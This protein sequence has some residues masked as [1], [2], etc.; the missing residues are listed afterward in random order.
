MGGKW[1]PPPNTPIRPGAYVNFESSGSTPVL[2]GDFG[3]VG[4]PIQANWGPAN[5]FVEVITDADRRT[6]YGIV[7]GYD[8]KT[9]AAPAAA[10]TSWLITEAIRGGSELVKAYRL[11][12][13]GSMAATLTLK[14]WTGSNELKIDAKYVG[15]R[16]NGWTVTVGPSPVFAGK[17]V[18][19]IT[20]GTTVLESWIYPTDD[21]AN[22]VT[23]LNSTTTGSILVTGTLVAGMTVQASEVTDLVVAAPLTAGAFG[24]QFNFG[25][26][27]GGVT[28]VANV[29]TT[30]GILFSASTVANVQTAV[31]AALVA[32]GFVAGNITVTLQVGSDGLDTAGAHTYRLTA[33]GA[34][35][36]QNITVSIINGPALVVPLAA[37]VPALGVVVTVI[38]AGA[39]SP[40]AYGAFVGVTGFNSTGVNGA[41]PNALSYTNALAAFETEGGFDLFSLD[42]VSEESIVGI[43][44]AIGA[45]AI[46][47]NDAG[48]Y[49]M[50]VVGGGATELANVGNLGVTSALSRSALYDSEWVVNIGVSGLDVTAPGGN[51]LSLTSAQCAPRLAGMIANAGIIGSVTFGEVT[52]VVK[53]NGAV[54]PAQIEAMIQ[55]GVIV[56]AK[57]GDFVRVEDGITTF[58]SLTDEKDFTFTQIRAVRAIQ[59]IGLDITEIVERDWIG[60]KINTTSVRDLLLATLGQYFSLLEARGVLV[61][62]TSVQLDTRYDNTKTNVFILVLAQFQFELK[63]VLLTVRVP[64]VA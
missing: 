26:T 45:W 57:R 8:N 13:A 16:P 4:M 47:N 2:P 61:A 14:D 3:R 1:S 33:S 46:I 63:R 48:R 52:D 53:V 41:A 24:I 59:Q 29:Q 28:P 51:T 20:E 35:A 17:D 64:T 50:A 44:A 36:N 58:I 6:T 39:R 25:N 11:V 32:G 40:L 34:L 21:V 5:A 37:L 19:T 7:D 42:G 23:Q 22:L 9:T 60:K 27:T 62:G 43:N 15:T 49:V 30:A 31:N 10:D 18:L 54:T 38:T 55:A 12:G 56:F